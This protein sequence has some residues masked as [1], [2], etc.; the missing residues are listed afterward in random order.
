M[1]VRPSTGSR[2]CP[3]I[4]ATDFTCPMFSATSTR[5]TG[6]NSPIRER[7]NSGAWNCGSPSSP[8]ASQA[9]LIAEKST[10][11]RATAVR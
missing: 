2:S 3:V 4:R 7:W 8:S 9:A 6:T 11:P 1:M 5:I 10:S